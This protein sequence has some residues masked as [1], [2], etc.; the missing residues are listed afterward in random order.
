[1][2][3]KELVRKLQKAMNDAGHTP[4]F[5]ESG[6]YASKTESALP[7][8]DFEITA[9]R[10][11]DPVAPPAG[12]APPWLTYLRK[13]S[14]KKETDPAFS[15][16]ISS[17][18]KY[19]GLPGY[20]TIS[21]KARAWCAVFIVVG[22]IATGQVYLSKGGAGA[23]NHCSAPD[24]YEYLDWKK[25]GMPEGAITGI[26]GTGNHVSQANGDCAPADLLKADA[27]F[28]AYGGNQGD[29]AK[30]STYPVKNLRCVGWYKSA[31]ERPRKI[32]VSRNCT[33]K[34]KTGESTR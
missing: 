1:M 11:P 22:G 14:G 5:A 26:K 9:K 6:N 20:K 33:S 8:Y 21:G 30:V 19:V 12:F 16:E 4:K 23:A 15:K 27:T 7:L 10:K 13:F 29:H 34:G 2:T 32:T 18:W 31:K 25:D 24:I 17:Y 28:D 3:D